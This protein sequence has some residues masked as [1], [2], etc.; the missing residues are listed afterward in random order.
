MGRRWNERS[1][2]FEPSESRKDNFTK[3]EIRKLGCCCC[4][5]C[6]IFDDATCLNEVKRSK[7]NKATPLMESRRLHSMI[8]KLEGDDESILLD[9][10]FEHEICLNRPKSVRVMT[11]LSVSLSP[12]ITTE[13]LGREEA[14]AER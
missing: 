11:S 14:E 13:R 9:F 1:C 3:E 7:P 8:C 5:C 12:P 2:F 10:I 4:G 6:W